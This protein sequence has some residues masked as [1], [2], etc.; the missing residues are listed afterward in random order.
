MY[1]GPAF[2]KTLNCFNTCSIFRLIASPRC[3]HDSNLMQG[4]ITMGY[5]EKRKEFR[6]CGILI[7]ANYDIFESDLCL[8]VKLIVLG[9]L[10]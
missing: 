9:S 6:R 2:T 4:I 7:S 3:E 1:K 8:T 10:F 5:L